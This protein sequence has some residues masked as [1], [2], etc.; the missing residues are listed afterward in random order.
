MSESSSELAD[1]TI[2]ELVANFEDCFDW[3]DRYGYI[4]E[5]GRKLPPLPDDAKTEANQ[6]QGCQSDAWMTVEEKNEEDLTRLYFAAGS[7]TFIV[8]GLIAV[9]VVAYSGLT[10]REILELDIDHLFDRIDLRKHLSPVRGNGL[11]AMVK[12]IRGLAEQHQH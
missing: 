10:P 2:D 1:L 12:K 9:L 3:D 8:R 6:I 4:I 7:D 5:L 11:L